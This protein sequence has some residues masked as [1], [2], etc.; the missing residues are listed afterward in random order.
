[1]FK[2][3]TVGK[4]IAAGFGIVLILL[5]IIGV[6]SF[7]GISSITGNSIHSVASTEY[8]VLILQKEIDH[9]TWL[10]KLM[11]YQMDISIKQLNVQTDDHKCG[12]GKWLY[13]DD[14]KKA[15]EAIPAL[16][17]LFKRMEK[18]HHE[19]HTSAID[20]E[21][22]MHKFDV[23]SVLS[24]L[25]KAVGDHYI[26]LSKVTDSIMDRKRELSVQLDYR[27]CNFGK[28][29]YGAEAAALRKD[30]PEFNT[31]FSKIEEPHKKLHN[32]GHE[33]EN[34]LKSGDFTGALNILKDVKKSYVPEIMGTI[35]EMLALTHK[36]VDDQNKA[37]E[38]YNNV[39]ITS[40]RNVQG[41]MHEAKAI[42][43]TELETA[44]SSLMSSANTSKSLVSVLGVI[45][46]VLGLAA[47]IFISRFLINSL[48]RVIKNLSGGS[49]QVASASG[50]VSTASQSLAEGASEQASSIEE[51]SSSLEE[52]SSMAKQ[53]S[54]NA[55]EA[56]NLAKTAKAAAEDGNEAMGEMMTAITEINE[57]SGQISRIIKTI[58][59]IAFQTN[60]L[61]LN[62]AVEAAR[63]GE[64][65]KGFAVVA[66]EV[67]NL[68][69]R[70][71]NAAK[72]TTQ[73]IEESVQK[74]GNGAKIAEKTNTSFG[75]ILENINKVA[76][77]VGEIASASK[78]QAEGVTQ[79]NT[80]VNQMD[81]VVQKNASSAE[82]S[83]SASEEL[84][85]QAE[86]LNDIVGELSSLVGD[87]DSGGT[88]RT[89]KR[90]SIG[91]PK[92]RIDHSGLNRTK[93]QTG[94]AVKK[95]DGE[96]AI[97]FEDDFSEF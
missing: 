79:I 8:N 83:A 24:N 9:L 38:I 49:D 70:A 11:E 73:L 20:I 34:K 18:P 14:R 54:D 33:M 85:S 26:W 37:S 12:L 48:S 89:M 16:A 94:M 47:A 3:L 69:Q 95:T 36:F 96:K 6:V 4:Q 40:L 35:K 21:K 50:Q 10:N 22:H 74:A 84:S 56:N 23:Q 5:T 92:D 77:L 42:I 59:E 19:L 63:A 31:L 82:E 64:A 28:W 32:S 88:G 60:L 58:E 52:M 90:Q 39:T 86:G 27:L 81:S 87:S 41:L 1:M 15:E 62:A 30:S 7:I 25:Q 97:P 68:A 2:N 51:T 65:G 91:K 44:Q 67:R 43:E 71:A 57:S 29:F 78:E 13:S 53:N 72:D 55:D 45:A 80:A 75:S 76:N 17:P 66:D 61:A 93:P 46:I